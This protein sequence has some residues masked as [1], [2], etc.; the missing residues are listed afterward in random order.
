MSWSEIT[1]IIFGVVAILLGISWVTLWARGNK[2]W[3][4]LK[5]LRDNYKKAVADGVIT[6]EE[7]AG[8]ADDLIDIIDH[9]TTLW[10]AVTNII[11]DIIVVIKNARLK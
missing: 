4:G 3:A 10:Q 7:K 2:L 5:N 6:D 11:V 9:A 8:I 1:T